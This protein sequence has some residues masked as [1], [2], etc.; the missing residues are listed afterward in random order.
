M[1][2]IREILRLHY[3]CGLSR[4]K[5]SKA[6]GCSRPT[7]AE[8][9]NRTQAAGLSWPLPETLEDDT[10][11]LACFQSKETTA[12]KIKRA[13][14]DCPYIHQELKKK[15]VTLNLL[16]EE[17]KQDNPDGY[18]LTQ[19][20][21]VYRQWRKTLDLV[22]RLDHK[23]GEKAFSD[24]AGKTLPIVINEKTGAEI[25]A[26]L[27]VCALGASNY[28]F[29]KLYWAEDTQAWCMGHADAF[30][31]FGGC[32]E[33]CVPD[34][35]KPVV[36]KASP[37]EPDINPSFAQMASHFG[38]A[39][40]PARVRHPKDKAAV[41]C[42]VGVATRWI[43][44]VL[45]NRKFFSLAE[46]NLAVA[47]LL[48]KLNNRPFKKLPGSRK[49]KFEAID[50]PA[51]KP[52]PQHRYEFM[53]VKKATVHIADYHVEYEGCWYSAPFQYRG[54]AIEIRATLHT[55]EI[56]FKG[57]RI[58]SH[59]RAFV[60][61]SRRTVNEHRP[62]SHQEYG[63]WPPERLIRWAAKIGPSTSS[64]IEKILQRFNV[65]ELS[66]RTCF[67]VL[68]LAKEAGDER[69][70]AA[71]NRALAINALSVKSIKS[72]L[73]SGLDKRPLPEKPRQL[74]IVHEN[75]RG[76]NSFNTPQTEEEKNVDSSNA[77]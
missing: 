35:P 6:L 54:R 12:E 76:A 13:Q 50:K 8:Y 25:Q 7:V 11:L 19:F 72:I 22:M 14:P 62:K 32:P 48:E 15:G 29:A 49:S 74:T 67:G 46:A 51:L 64:L 24:F 55:V 31:F 37:Y 5:I 57:K 63:A 56:Y 40:I 44:A 77:R 17:Y 28:T 36:T 65:P 53:H 69:L 58:A 26:H 18:Q 71:C 3:S 43:L 1:R 73:D 4:K 33:I 20:C 30:E 75:I 47:E 52:L 10:K 59:A 27:F 23:A 9:I 68:R 70:E 34:N 45:R 21:E 61:G 60:R 16:W 41:E 2:M 66:Y 39:V 38:I 42:A